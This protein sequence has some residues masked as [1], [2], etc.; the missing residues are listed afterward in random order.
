MASTTS[1]VE[2]SSLWYRGWQ[3][4]RNL[5]NVTF[6]LIAIG[7]SSY[8]FSL[9]LWRVLFLR[10]FLIY[11][12][13]SQLWSIADLF[14]NAN[15]NCQTIHKFLETI[16]SFEVFSPSPTSTGVSKKKT[17]PKISNVVANSCWWNSAVRVMIA[18]CIS[19]LNFECD[20]VARKNVRLP[21]LY[22]KQFW[23]YTESITAFLLWFTL[24]RD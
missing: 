17:G 13:N 4:P 7:K 5:P 20:A 22:P 14:S 3:R 24:G 23:T 15:C 16:L 6:S 8:P 21:I 10:V 19:V 2:P 11:P 12:K 18:T 9:R 1:S